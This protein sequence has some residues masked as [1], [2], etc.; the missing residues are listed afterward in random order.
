MTLCVT[1]G[2][3]RGERGVAVSRHRLS[4]S[5]IP[6]AS[7]A[8]DARLSTASRLSSA[9]LRRRSTSFS[10]RS[11]ASPLLARC[12]SRALS[13]A[14]RVASLWIFGANHTTGLPPRPPA[15]QCRASPF[16]RPISARAPRRASPDPSPRARG[17][18]GALQ[19]PAR[20]LGERLVHQRATLRA[21]LG[22]GGALLV[23]GASTERTHE[24]REHPAERL[25]ALVERRR[26]ERALAVGAR[27]VRVDRRCRCGLAARRADRDRPGSVRP[28]STT[29]W[30][31]TSLTLA[32]RLFSSRSSETSFRGGVATLARRCRR[33]SLPRRASRPRSRPIDHVAP[34]LASPSRPARPRSPDRRA[35]SSSSGALVS[36]V[37]KCASS[38]SRLG[39]TWCPCRVEERPGRRGRRAGERG[40]ARGRR[41]ATRDGARCP[42][43][44]R[45]RGVCPRRG[46]A[47]RV[48][49]QRHRERK[50]LK[51]RTG[52][53]LR[54]H[55]PRHCVLRRQR[56]RRH[57]AARRERR[58][59]PLSSSSPPQRRDG[60]SAHLSIGSRTTYAQN[61]PS[62]ANSKT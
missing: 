23:R 30:D 7:S 45:I 58:P 24:T 6:L 41:D 38:R 62:S 42:R 13:A 39:T 50:R 33:P 54:R 31:L 4:S 26:P 36:W 34:R 56:R 28:R 35:S 11:R 57:P 17:P 2:T 43:R 48:R 37:P 14:S 8:G 3:T 10:A 46:H 44:A 49:S 32:R 9:F 40:V 53:H 59:A 52:R 21:A 47:P 18:R 60:T 16:S 20:V 12:S 25:R 61:E 5:S 29:P 15:R 55:H 22:R 51:T 27:I 19:R 1:R